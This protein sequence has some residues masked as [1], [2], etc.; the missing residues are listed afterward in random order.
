MNNDRARLEEIYK[1]RA[2]LSSRYSLDNPGNRFNFDLLYRGINDRLTSTF[3][4]LTMVRMLD[5]GSGELFWPEKMI[6]MGLTPENCIGSDLLLRRL[7]DGR[8]MGRQVTAVASSAAALPFESNS[9][10]LV[11]QL[12]MM[13]SVPEVTTRKAIALE[14]I[15]VLRP[16]GYI[17]WYDFRFNNPSNPYTRAIRK[18]EIK[19]LFV[20]MPVRC[21]KITLLPQLARKLGKKSALLL[22]L[23]YTLPILRTHYLGMIGPKA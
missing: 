23:F 10:D 21:Q 17:L 20:E 9:F 12:T 11:C 1:K 18:S 3:G 4:D 5:L 14:M 15:R 13:T 8:K 2:G 16:G 6:L 19:K 22:N 7:I